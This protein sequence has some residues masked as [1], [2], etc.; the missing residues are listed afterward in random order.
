MSQLTTQDL[1]NAVPKLEAALGGSAAQTTGMTLPAGGSPAGAQ[2][3]L[4]AAR[5]V[6][7]SS[8][9]QGNHDAVS[10]APAMIMQLGT[11][12]SGFVSY[13]MGPNGAGLWSQS[14][15]TNTMSAAPNLQ[16]GIGTAGHYV[17][18]YN[19]P[20]PGNAGHVFIDIDGQWFEDAD[21][22]RACAR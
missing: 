2:R 16:P 22:D 7:G 5:A 4:A 1:L 13:L 8:Y 3:M 19:N 12:C 20:L 21:R 15:V 11:D 17:T 9:N 18:I 6:I 14:Y 10:D